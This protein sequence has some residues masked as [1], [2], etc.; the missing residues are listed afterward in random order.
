MYVHV[1]NKRANYFQTFI[2]VYS[3]L[4]SPEIAAVKAIR[5]QIVSDTVRAPVVAGS[6]V[7]YE[8]LRVGP[9]DAYVR[10]QMGHCLDV[11]DDR[12]E[13]PFEVDC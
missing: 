10:R 9:A 1:S 11:V 3:L 8:P 13:V 6:W 4:T 2:A 5:E 12:L 7:R